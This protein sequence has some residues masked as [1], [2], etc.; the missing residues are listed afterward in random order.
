MSGLAD[1]LGRRGED[2]LEALGE[3]GYMLLVSLAAAV[4]LGLPLGMLVYLTRRGGA[5]PNRAVW[6][7]GNLFINVV[8]S[9]PFLLLVVFLVP[10]TRLVYGTTFGTP[11]ATFSLCF[12]A[13][14]IYA[15]LVEQILR[16]IS[17]GIPR[18]ARTMG[19]TLPQTIVRFLLPEAFPGLAYALT[20]ATISLLSY[21]T[22]LGVVGG[23]GIGD[24]ALRYG[25][26]E[27]DYPLMYFT[28]AVILVVVLVIQSIGHRLSIRL[29]HR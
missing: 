29:D 25:Y 7:T 19:A 6:W 10:V 5:A 4:L 26:Q 15:R 14:A 17:P 27:Y 28:I 23:G 1:S 2:L 22:V 12:V 8:R 18:V 20:S 21:S 9:F 13:V 3:T 24:F 11:A 16:E